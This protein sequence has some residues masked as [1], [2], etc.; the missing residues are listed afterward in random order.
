L[1]RVNLCRRGG[2][3]KGRRTGP[4][5]RIPPARLAFRQF[6]PTEHKSGRPRRRVRSRD[7]TRGSIPPAEVAGT[8]TRIPGG[9]MRCVAVSCAA[10][11]AAQALDSAGSV[12]LRTRPVSH[13]ARRRGTHRRP[14]RQRGRRLLPRSAIE[15][16]P[17]VEDSPAAEADRHS[18]DPDGHCRRAEQCPRPLRPGTHRVPT[19]FATQRA[20]ARHPYPPPLPRGRSP[21]LR[22]QPIPHRL[23]RRL[24][25]SSRPQQTR[26]R[27]RSQPARRSAPFPRTR[28]IPEPTPRAGCT[29]LDR[30]RRHGR[31]SDWV[32]CSGHGHAARA[33][34]ALSDIIRIDQS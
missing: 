2:S 19:P 33:R 7:A 22:R 28:S 1:R 27:K 21:L 3:P 30:R 17:V 11:P 6:E 13:C 26:R 23:V 25:Q 16:V 18:G 29:T 9:S 8:C 5:P 14:P 10:W 15:R 20:T 24:P 31:D 4:Y 12:L 34:R 32:L